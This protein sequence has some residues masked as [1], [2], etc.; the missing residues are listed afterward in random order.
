MVLRKGKV[1]FFDM[2]RMVVRDLS[3]NFKR[4][5]IGGPTPAAR[6]SEHEASDSVSVQRQFD[7]KPNG[8]GTVAANCGRLL[9]VSKRG[10]T[11]RWIQTL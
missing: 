4:S 10:H 5:G 7:E 3:H 1:A 8:I 11:S 9:P 6:T 2:H